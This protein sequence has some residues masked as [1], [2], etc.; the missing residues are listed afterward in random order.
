MNIGQLRS[1]LYDLIHK[2]GVIMPSY[3]QG[4]MSEPH[5]QKVIQYRSP[6]ANVITLT[7]SYG[8]HGSFYCVEGNF[9]GVKVC[10]D[11]YFID[12]YVPE[13]KALIEFELESMCS[14]FENGLVRDNNWYSDKQKEALQNL[15]NA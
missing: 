9:N 15:I 4:G 13:T 10:S 11:L 2:Y 8:S 5:I 14:A 1:K 6:H 12:K 7:Y 3:M